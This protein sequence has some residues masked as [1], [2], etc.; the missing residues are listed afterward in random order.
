M[1]RAILKRGK[2]Q[3]VGKLPK[4]WREGQELL[5][6]S[7]VPSDDPAEIKAWYKK[8]IKLSA[9]I[10][11]EDHDRMAAAIAE[12]KRESKELM[13]AEMGLTRS[14]SFSSGYEGRSPCPP[15]ETYSRD[16]GS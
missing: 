12:Q 16:H 9:Q 7:T 1:I 8:L 3:P 6:D 10:P 13:R 5:V 11:K 15:N 14:D 4:H 2:I